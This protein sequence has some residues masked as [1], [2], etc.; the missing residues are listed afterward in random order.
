MK[1]LALAST[2]QAKL[3]G[4]FSLLSFQICLLRVV[5]PAWLTVRKSYIC[6]LYLVLNVPPVKPVYVSTW[7]V[8]VLVTV[9]L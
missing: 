4:A 2:S 3:Y 5:A 7:L 9:A 6:L 8:S 1:T